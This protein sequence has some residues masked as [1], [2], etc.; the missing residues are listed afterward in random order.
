M[1]TGR[2]PIADRRE[3]LVARGPRWHPRTIH[4]V[5]DD[6]A[7]AFPDR[8]LVLAD[9]RVRTYADVVRHSLRI[10]AGL[11]A[12]GVRPGEKVALVMGNF[13][14]YVALKYAISR[15]GA[16]AVPVNV[17]LKADELAYV[18]RQ[19]DS[20][21][22]ITMDS[23]RGVDHLAILDAACPGWADD[24]GSA[25]PALRHVVVFETGEKEPRKGCRTFRSLDAAPVA[26]P[27]VA[28]D[29]I[30]DILFTS[31][32]T[33]PPKGV[34]L[35]H[36]M[37]M[38]TAYGSAYARAFEDGR[39]IIFSLP[40]YHVFGYV[41]GML[42]VPFVGGAIIPRLKFDPIDTLQGIE[43]HRASDALL[44][45]AMSLALIETVEPEQ[46]DLSSLHYAL[47][48]GGKAPPRLWS[49]LRERLGVTE[50]TTG[51]GMTET[52]ASTT[53]TQPDDP[54]QRLL[55]TN[56]RLREVGPAA[57]PALDGILVDYRV[58]DLVS[59]A[60][61]PP[62][63]MGELQARG[64][65]VTKGYYRKPL[66][67]AQAFTSDGWLRTGDL[68]SIDADRYITLLG[69][70]KESYRCGGEQVLPS[71]VEDVIAEFAGVHMVHVAPLPDE[72]MGEVGVAFV[73][74]AAGSALSEDAIIE[75]AR[76]R[77]ARFKVPRHVIFITES[78]IPAT[79]SGRAK[80]FEL[81]GMAQE[82]L[83]PR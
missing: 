78:E 55:T 52:T 58:V 83:G 67:T 56:G 31:G 73:V 69:R 61:L 26:M 15:I 47:A 33:G 66:E 76:A 6:A 68:G 21:A 51:Y 1:P 23:F 70:T 29:A 27:P 64:I 20:V 28:A 3:D 75:Q 42:A 79:A 46:F 41:E 37:L 22:L 54:D 7:L 36:D 53:V 49:L 59:G 72:R 45:P 71:E 35:T 57:D 24:G 65:G 4:E 30:C 5:L 14:D 81:T 80:K 9:D 8:P 63:E 40:L 34:Q 17:L 39:R 48:S 2:K 19:S 16:V 32:T 38:R 60:E 13:P 62:G 44:I 82:R 43:R 77:L 18:L 10:A 25:L 50:I 11:I 74:R 12:M